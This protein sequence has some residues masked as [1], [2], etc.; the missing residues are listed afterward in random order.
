M[1]DRFDEEDEDK[2]DRIAGIFFDYESPR[3]QYRF[4][5][6]NA[7]PAEINMLLAAEKKNGGTPPS[8][9]G[10]AKIILSDNVWI[11][12]PRRRSPFG[13]DRAEGKYFPSQPVH[14]ET[15]AAVEAGT[16]ADYADNSGGFSR[17]RQ[18]VAT[19]PLAPL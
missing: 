17:P 11:F 9:L 6:P 3:D 4:G 10:H 1:H 16:G 15:A 2:K 12:K 8:N 19:P 18:T 7:T 5:Y 14:W 13:R